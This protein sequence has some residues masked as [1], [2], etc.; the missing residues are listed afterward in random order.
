MLSSKIL[1]S[2]TRSASTYTFFNSLKSVPLTYKTLYNK[3]QWKE[4]KKNLNYFLSIECPVIKSSSHQIEMI[5]VI[6]T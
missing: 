5:S 4:K 1:L 3:K 6:S 2:F